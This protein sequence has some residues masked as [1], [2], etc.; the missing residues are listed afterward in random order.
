M[1]R[2]PMNPGTQTYE[3][4]RRQPEREVSVLRRQHREHVAA[5]RAQERAERDAPKAGAHK[6]GRPAAAIW[7]FVSLRR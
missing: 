6:I 3:R 4:S 1:Y 7:A 2:P 5:M